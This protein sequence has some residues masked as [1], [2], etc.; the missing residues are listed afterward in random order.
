MGRFNKDLVRLLPQLI[1]QEK[2]KAALIEHFKDV[3]NF[4][5]GI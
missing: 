2:E 3:E 4:V 1:S 5:K